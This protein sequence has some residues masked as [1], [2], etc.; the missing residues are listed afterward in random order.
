MAQLLKPSLALRRRPGSRF[1]PD[2]LSI[3]DPAAGIRL[4]S[5]T[6]KQLTDLYLLALARRHGGKFATFDTRIQV[7]TVT[8]GA[9]AI[10]VIPVGLARPS[11]M[12]DG[13]SRRPGRLR[14]RATAA[15]RTCRRNGGRTAPAFSIATAQQFV[16][17]SAGQGSA[18][19]NG[20]PGADEARWHSRHVSPKSSLARAD[21]S[22][23]SRDSG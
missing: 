17:P 2:S 8:G 21:P 22:P 3:A 4:H 9:E 10:E 18:R 13:R 16:I 23:A 11:R 12:A 1:L 14:L 6:P 20:L 15:G 7:E 5:A 19:A